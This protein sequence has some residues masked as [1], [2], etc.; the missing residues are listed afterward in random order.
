MLLYSSPLHAI[1]SIARCKILE[2]P[3][4]YISSPSHAS[5]LIFLHHFCPSLE[6]TRVLDSLYQ[7]RAR[8]VNLK[9]KQPVK[10]S[11]LRHSPM[12][13]ARM[14]GAQ[15][16]WHATFE[17]GHRNRQLEFVLDIRSASDFRT[18]HRIP[19]WRLTHTLALPPSGQHT[20]PSTRTRRRGV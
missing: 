20:L 9:L 3:A 8:N 12:S 4:K 14:M 15:W 17:S 18:A 1:F 5:P 19:I 13:R 2:L 10:R 7:K 6:S 11:T 16:G